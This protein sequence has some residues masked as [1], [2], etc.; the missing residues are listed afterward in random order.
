MP[1]ISIQIKYPNEIEVG[2]PTAQLS[3]RRDR[4][5]RY[6]ISVRHKTL[7]LY[8]DLSAP[9]L[10]AL[11]SK[12]DSL[13][14]NWDSKFE[15]SKERDRA[16]A[17]VESAEQ[18]SEEATQKQN[19]LFK[20]LDN[21]LGVDHRVNWKS[22]SDNS[23][24]P[25]SM[26]F[27]EPEPILTVEPTPTY[28]E[29]KIT[30]LEICLFR[31][32]AIIEKSKAEFG[33]RLTA[34]ERKLEAA[35]LLHN[36]AVR[37]WKSRK[38]QYLRSISEEKR[39]FFE[40]QS[41]F[42]KKLTLLANNWR[43]GNPGAIAEHAGIVMEKSDYMDLFE[44]SYEVEF[45]N[46]HKT[47]LVEYELPPP[48]KFP[49]LKSVKFNKSTGEFKETH[50]SEKERSTVYDNVCY[51]ICLRTIHELYQADEWK[52]ILRIAFNG[53]ATDV[54]QRTGRDV[55][56]CILSVV[57]EREEF[58]PIDLRRV[59]PKPCFKLLKGVSASALSSLVA[60][61]PLVKLNRNDRRFVDARDEVSGLDDSTNLATMDWED[62]E[63]LVRQIFEREFSNRGGEVKVTQ[64]SRDGGVDAV[65]F[66]PDPISGGKIVI[67][68]KRYTKVVGV[69]AVRDLYGTIL[70]EGA[71]KGILVTTAD[72][73][74]DAHKFAFGKPI[75][76]ISGSNLL[77]LLSKHGIKAK[78][79]LKEARKE[80]GLREYEQ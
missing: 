23:D 38:E 76:L 78:I 69:S 30:L 11:Q 50:I 34:H 37:I 15:N 43:N 28:K 49:T 42:N 75:T 6:S 13:L 18:L 44:K 68:A 40:A 22:L 27:P 1:Q 21:A 4:I 71:S 62:F 61:P 79:D 54:D 9:D 63:H 74:P 41:E 47:L 10:S 80:L 36:E 46:D 59:E 7:K 70:N 19:F 72:Y 65:A 33:S 53:F 2:Q 39:V 25:K 77:F 57:A 16:A 8:K 51:Q 48:S 14:S 35:S 24:F 58:E 52:H 73:G 67:Q 66:D 56:S 26:T 5:L 55:R 17:G 60:V 64:S 45:N 3:A 32:R 20:I 31:T 29:P 12:V